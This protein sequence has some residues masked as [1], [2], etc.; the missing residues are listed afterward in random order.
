[1]SAISSIRSIENKPDGCGGKDC[2]KKFCENN[3]KSEI[4]IKKAAGI[5]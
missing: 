4:V 1:M 3:L 5:I 2:M